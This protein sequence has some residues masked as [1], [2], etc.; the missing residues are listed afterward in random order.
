MKTW[1]K[2]D[3]VALHIENKC[4]KESAV[5]DEAGKEYSTSDLLAYEDFRFSYIFCHPIVA[6]PL[7]LKKRVRSSL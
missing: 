1:L 5:V 3:G 4:E 7:K 6:V 2:N